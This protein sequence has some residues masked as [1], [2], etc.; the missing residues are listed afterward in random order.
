[1][2]FSH[3][4]LVERGA[5]WLQNNGHYRYRCQIILTELSTYGL[6]I[7]DVIGF[8]HHHTNLIECKTSLSDFKADFKKLHRKNTAGM[9]NWRMYL[10]PAGLIPSDMIHDGWG[11]LYCHEKKITIEKHPADHNEPEVRANEYYLL[12]SIALRA[13]IDG[14]LPTILRTKKEREVKE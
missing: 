14:L 12:Y 10:C 7:P 6:E 5:K 13:K 11:L 4:E 2:T 3:S 9:G 8:S 1:M